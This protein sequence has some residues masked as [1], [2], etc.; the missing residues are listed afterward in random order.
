MTIDETKLSAG[1]DQLAAAQ[2][3]AAVRAAAVTLR[4]SLPTSAPAPA[5]TPEPTPAPSGST[6]ARLGF[7]PGGVLQWVSQT[8]LDRELDALKATGAKWLRHDFDWKSCENTK[9]SYNW[10]P[11]D[12]MVNGC[13][14]RGLSICATVAYTPP[15]ARPSGTTDKCAPTNIADYVNF[16]KACV[17][18]YLPQGVRV[19]EIWNEVNIL[20]FWQPRPD[21]VKYTAML[22]A[23]YAAIK[24]ID[25]GSTVISAGL[26]PAGGTVG[27]DHV[28]PRNFL[29]AMYANGAKGSFDAFGLHPY[30]FPY[31]IFAVGDWNQW[32]SMDKTFAIMQANGDGAKKIWATEYGA[33]TGTVSGRSVSESTQAQFVKDAVTEWKKKSYAGQLMWY[34]LRDNGT[35]LTD[36]EFNFGLM[37]HDFTAKPA[38]AEFTRQAA[39]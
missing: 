20:P 3:L 33:P 31:G 22:K 6:G 17:T 2:D 23:S 10:G 38:L 28:S 34:S 16:V 32:Y 37:R 36:I 27:T 7:A 4:S 1:F 5:P 30:A 12:R 15:W 11:I 18:R 8:D 14:S 25:P 21:P 29:T 35:N 39:L 26:A 13:K 9:G 24:A 19:W